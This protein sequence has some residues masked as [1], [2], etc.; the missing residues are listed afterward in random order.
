MKPRA[1]TELA[2]SSS[3]P[4]SLRF[5]VSL[6]YHLRF[7]LVAPPLCRYSSAS[8][9]V[10][11]DSSG[12]HLNFSEAFDSTT[13]VDIAKLFLY[14]SGHDRNICKKCP[15]LRWLDQRPSYTL[16]HPKHWSVCKPIL[17]FE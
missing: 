5:Y 1:A 9:Y 7:L 14:E 2:S 4:A 8:I 16:S 3:S 11:P 15:T 13:C 6:A 12:E 17:H 10:G